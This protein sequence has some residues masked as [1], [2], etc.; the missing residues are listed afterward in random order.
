MT[1]EPSVAII[2]L[3]WNGR[4][5]LDD[6]L[7]ALQTQDYPHYDITLVDNASS[8]D[9]AAFVREHFPQVTVRVNP[10][11]L[12][13]AAGNNVALRERT[14]DF[15]VLVNPDVV[16]AP[17]WLRQLLAPFLADSTI[18][19][20]GCKLLYPG[21]TMIQHAGGGISHPQAMPWHI[22][23]RETDEGQHNTL[24]DVDYVIGAV[25]AI[26]RETLA[27]A[28]L[29]DEG[30]FLYYE[31]VDF[32]FA[33]RQAGFRV[34][35][36]PQAVATHI[37][38][39]VAVKGSFAYLRRFHTGRWRFL[40][41]HF[42]TEEIL[43]ETLPAEQS[44]LAAIDYPERLAAA[45]AY[46]SI[47]A[48]LPSIWQARAASG[49]GVPAAI[50]Q[51]IQAGIKQLQNR[52]WQLPP[53]PLPAADLTRYAQ[54]EERPFT[55]RVPLLGP[56]LARFR[57]TWNNVASRW[58][59]RQLTDQQNAYNALLAQQL[60]AYETL[61]Q[62]QALLLRE[63]ATANVQHQADLAELQAVVGRLTQQLNEATRL[64]TG[65]K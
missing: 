28:G 48:M 32:C 64:G 51:E 9:S 30:Y 63:L 7:T 35:V 50:R 26:R 38:S 43:A 19:V 11:N 47:S 37:E 22:G 65:S 56:L 4:H 61:L 5:L 44:W 1:T 54:I 41:K 45:L 52:A 40:L 60:A 53:L 58:Y 49:H 3:N 36:V 57:A 34:V 2:V 46:E 20:A 31:D 23:G 6:C 25:L 12:G 33:A 62:Q 59:V 14:A 21:G 15:A 29:F 17:G 10:R 18:G 42:A 24:R 13:F 27:Q 8:D 16:V 55:S 39:A